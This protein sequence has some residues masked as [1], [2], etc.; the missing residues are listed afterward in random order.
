M[1][2]RK[3]T[4]AAGSLWTLVARVLYAG[5]ATC[6]LVLASTLVRDVVNGHAWRQANAVQSGHQPQR[7]CLTERA[8]RAPTTSRE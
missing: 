6:L 1:S 2:L 5:W 8:P 4:P 3:W 7:R